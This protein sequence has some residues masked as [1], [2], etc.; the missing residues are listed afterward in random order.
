[1]PHY[2]GTEKYI[3]LDTALAASPRIVFTEK[4]TRIAEGLTLIAASEI[5]RRYPR[6]AHG[7]TER[8]GTQFVGDD[9]RHEQYLL[10]EDAGKR[11]LI[12]G[13]SHIGALD[14]ASYFQ[15]DVMIGGFHFSKLPLDEA[16]AD[17]ARTLSALPTVYY[18]C[19]CTGKEQFDFMKNYMPRLSYF[20]GGQTI[21]I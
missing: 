21:E 4:R 11:V 13:C 7:L 19:H 3:G 12:S 2:N 9:F 18:T 20:G 15:P 8:L 16:L 10:I 5:P 17:A 1:L 6:I 14:I